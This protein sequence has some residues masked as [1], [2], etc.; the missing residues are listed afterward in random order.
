MPLLRLIFTE[1]TDDH[2]RPTRRNGQT[3]FAARLQQPKTQLGLLLYM[4]GRVVRTENW[5]TPEYLT[6]DDRVAGGHVFTCDSSSWQAAVLLAAGFTLEEVVTYPPYAYGSGGY[7]FGPYGKGVAPAG[8]YGG[9][10]YGAGY[11]GGP[12]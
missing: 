6:A 1:G 3:A 5:F 10:G 7:G 2:V 12:S 11:Y 8:L 4:D 9:S